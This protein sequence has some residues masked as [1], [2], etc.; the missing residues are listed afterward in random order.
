M[1][2]LLI[3]ENNGV[4]ELEL[5]NGDEIHIGNRRCLFIEEAHT[6]GSVDTQ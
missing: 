5:N 4:R 2:R 6:T 1:V 3:Y